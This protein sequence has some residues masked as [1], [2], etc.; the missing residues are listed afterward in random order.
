MQHTR[1][2]TNAPPFAR[3]SPQLAGNYSFSWTSVRLINGEARTAQVPIDIML[4]L[5]MFCRF[6][7]FCR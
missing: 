4:S 7:L 2:R 6:Y 1:P 3:P 5:P